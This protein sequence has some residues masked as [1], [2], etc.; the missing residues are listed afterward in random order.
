MKKK[1]SF[2]ELLERLDEQSAQ[3]N[4]HLSEANRYFDL[5]AKKME[6]LLRREEKEIHGTIRKI[7]QA[8]KVFKWDSTNK[9]SKSASSK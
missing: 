9:G 4:T 6:A 7:K 1:E 5:A 8:I 3:F 2:K